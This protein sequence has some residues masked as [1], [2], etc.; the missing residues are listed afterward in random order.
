MKESIISVIVAMDEKRGIGRNNNLLFRISEDF[1]RMNN[2]TRGHPIVMGRGTFE[3]LG[4]VLPGNRTHI[5]ITHNQEKVKSVSF[6]SSEVKIA[7]SLTK[8]ISLAKNCLGSEEI[9][10]FGGGQIYNEAIK[11]NLADKLYLTIV[12]GNFDADT[13]FPEY[14]E[15]KKIIFEKEGESEGYKY[16]FL[17]LKR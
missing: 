17:E 2:L 9:F 7:S 8:G 3:S 16:K 15:F 6:Y 13:Y 12:K 10:I 1:K 14:P 4:R 11:K 5:V